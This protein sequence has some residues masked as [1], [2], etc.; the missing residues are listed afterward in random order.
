M[1]EAALPKQAVICCEGFHDRA[2][3][4]GWLLS[5]G[6]ADHGAPGPGRSSRVAVKDHTGERVAEGHF[7]FWREE[8][9]IRV[10]PCQ[11]KDQVVPQGLA[12]LRRNQRDVSRLVLCL[13]DDRM[14]PVD[15]ELG[16]PAQIAT[17][18]GELRRVFGSEHVAWADPATKTEVVLWGGA[19]RV[20]VVHWRCD[21]PAGP[22]LPEQQ[23]L[24][25]LVCAALVAAHP[26]RGQPVADWLAS[27]PEPPPKNPKEHA[28]SHMAG[29]YSH[30]RGGVEA[31][32]EQLWSEPRVRAE[33]E[34][35]L[36]QSNAWAVATA[37]AS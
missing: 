11:G 21:D 29:W 26:G 35:R 5:L 18:L 22:T 15:S 4:R 24:E 6:W 10:V 34:R 3:W 16:A 20:S 9:F 32:Y 12:F 28:W 17:L 2:F 36:Q 19:T 33:L 25:R 31:F 8:R 14:G 7:G 30:D 23:T 37:L 13:D 27:R 1:T